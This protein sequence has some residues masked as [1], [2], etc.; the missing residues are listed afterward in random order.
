[1]S[2]PENDTMA[3]M[4]YFVWEWNT[5]IK[6]REIIN[7][8][9]RRY[10]LGKKKMGLLLWKINVKEDQE[11]LINYF[12][13]KEIRKNLQLKVIPDLR[14]DP[15]MEGK[16]YCKENYLVSWQKWNVDSRLGKSNQGTE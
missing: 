8:P 4:E 12:Q 9:K 11:K 1:M 13:I 10:I 14:L 2:Y 7:K 3:D 15:V 16:H 5:W 6:Y